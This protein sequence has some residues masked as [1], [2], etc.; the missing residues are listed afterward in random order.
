MNEYTQTEREGNLICFVAY[1]KL[2]F[3]LLN[4][5]NRGSQSF[6]YAGAFENVRNS[7]GRK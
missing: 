3:S 2:L 6:W 7:D 4:I 5:L 1:L